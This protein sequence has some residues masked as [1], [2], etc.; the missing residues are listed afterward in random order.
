M[1]SSFPFH[2]HAARGEPRVIEIRAKRFAYS[3]NIIKLKK[4]ERV[5][6]K[7]TSEDVTHGFFLDGYG[8]EFFVYPGETRSVMLKADKAGKFMFR[9][10]VTCGE[11]HPYMVGYLKVSPNTTFT[12]GLLGILIL[13]LGSLLVT[14]VRKK[15]NPGKLFGII[16]IKWRFELTRFK[17]VRKLLKSR[18]FPLGLI[19]FNLF[20]FTVIL[21]A[22]FA[23]GN[24]TGNYNFGIMIVWILWWFL[25]MSFMV[26]II[27]RFWCMMCPFPLIGDWLQRGK[28]FGVG[29]LKSWGL[30]KKWPAKWRNL[31]PVTILFFISTWASGF[32]TVRPI[33]TFILLG[34]ITLTVIGSAA[35]VLHPRGLTVQSVG[36]MAQVLEPVLGSA[37]A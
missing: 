37:T 29:R 35:A 30:N 3:P 32:F 28:L 8:L 27:G 2:L 15:G 22:G 7:L 26:P 24:S 10:S 1:V 20:V 13:G 5:V 9:C 33:A 21:F 17:I 11:F 19:L 23:G 6:L 25:L 16:P 12:L 31:W 34:I 18:W 36:E 4:G 14:L